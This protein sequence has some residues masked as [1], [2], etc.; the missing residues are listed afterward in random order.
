MIKILAA[1][2]SCAFRHHELLNQLIR[3]DINGKYKGT[4]LGVV[5]AF[6]NPLLMLA[7]Y[8]AVFK[9]VFKARWPETDDSTS[10]FALMLFIGLLIHGVAADVIGRA[11]NVIS[12]NKNYVKKVVFPL[13]I[14]SWSL[15]ISALVQYFFGL[16]ILLVIIA[17]WGK[18]I[19]LTWLLLPITIAPYLLFLLAAAW[20]LYALGV[21]FKDINQI[22]PSLITVLL[23][24]STV[25]FPFS[26]APEIIQPLLSFNPLTVIIE[27][28]RDLLFYGRLPDLIQLSIY[29][30]ISLAACVIGFS[31]FKRLERGFA[32]AL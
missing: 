31:I 14:L 12:A 26:H 3:R 10:E 21:Y 5:W 28:S 9:F 1:P 20:T 6:I 30:S 23:F 13:H 25:F 27:S 29:S 24:T 17:A 4:L 2:F 18:P 32:D 11:V 7:V 8:T 19:Y 16:V 22:T 15:V